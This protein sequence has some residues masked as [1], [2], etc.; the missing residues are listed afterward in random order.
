MHKWIVV[1]LSLA[2]PLFAQENT[3]TIGGQVLDQSGAGIPG[4]RVI[5]RNLQTGIERMAVTNETANYTIPLLPIVSHLIDA[6]VY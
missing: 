3:A 4:A 1:V 6:S 2:L 5:A